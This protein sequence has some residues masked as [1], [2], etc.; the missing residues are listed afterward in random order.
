MV[1]I[2]LANRKGGTGKSTVA[3]NLSAEFA[4]LGKKVLLIDLDT[5]GHATLGLGFEF[6]RG[7]PSVHSLFS[8]NILDLNRAVYPTRYKNLYLSPADPMFEH[9]K[10]GEKRNILKEQLSK[11]DFKSRFDF[12]ILDTAPSFDNL[13]MNALLVADYVLVPFQPHYLAIEGIKNLSRLF[14]KIASTENPSL[15][16]LGFVP[17]MHNLRILH[18][19]Y[20]INSISEN[21]GRG[22]ILPGIR[23]DIKVVEAFE[24]G[25]PVRYYS[26]SCR[27]VQ[28]FRGLASEILRQL[29]LS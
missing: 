14:F 13:L 6:K 5:Q 19:S 25:M 23:N 27:A 24:K 10:A 22:K 20:V 17:I 11:A 15:R 7:L 29:F 26:P 9:G 12:V 16:L 3:V 8:G 2:T 4:S 21:F 18:H 1:V 28:D